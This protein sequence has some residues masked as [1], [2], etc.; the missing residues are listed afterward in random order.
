VA[1]TLALGLAGTLGALRQRPL[2]L[3]RNE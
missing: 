3:L 1:L 2:S